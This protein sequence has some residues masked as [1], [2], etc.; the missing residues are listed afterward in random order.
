MYLIYVARPGD[1]KPIRDS[2]HWYESRREADERA[3]LVAT[4]TDDDVTVW[5]GR[6]GDPNVLPWCQF[7]GRMVVGTKTRWSTRNNKAQCLARAACK[8]RQ[9]QQKK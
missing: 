6:V 9:R 2:D 8:T 7:C 1:H 3:A 4:R 5:V